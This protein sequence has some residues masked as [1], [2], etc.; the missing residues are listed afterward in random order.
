MRT[1]R[2]Q[3]IHMMLIMLY[4][5]LTLCRVGNFDRKVTVNGRTRFFTSFGSYPRTG[6]EVLIHSH[7]PSLTIYEY[8]TVL[9][10]P[11]TNF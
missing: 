5:V 2:L 9:D 7:S 1:E 11:C 8:Y 4:I 6:K 10:Y 3:L